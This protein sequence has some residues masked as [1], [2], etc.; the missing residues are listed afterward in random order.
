MLCKTQGASSMAEHGMKPFSHSTA[1][2]A[3]QFLNGVQ[4]HSM[5]ILGYPYH[6]ILA[7]GGT[8]YVANKAELLMPWMALTLFIGTGGI[9]LRR[10]ARS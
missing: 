8:A 9:A 3:I 10:K 5:T 4:L 6:V 7:F 1:A 2:L